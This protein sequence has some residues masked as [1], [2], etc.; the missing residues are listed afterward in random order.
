M[1]ESELEVLLLAGRFEVRGS[2]AY[3]LRLAAGLAEKGI[4][5]R[6]V[7]PDAGLVDRQM[8]SRLQIEE[9]RRLN[10]P[11]LGKLL[12][13]Y[14]LH[15]ARRPIPHLIHIQSRRALKIGNWLSRQ[16]QR[17]YLV[18]MHQHLPPDA[19]LRLNREWCRRIIAVS[20]S[21]RHD[22]LDRLRVP[23]ELVTVIPC[24]VETA[25]QT[26]A[27]IS[28]DFGHTPVI[29][30][31]GPLETIKGFPYFLG[32]A[33]QVLEVRNNVEFL[34]AGAGPEEANLRRVARELGIADK[35]TFVPFLR[36]FTDS[37][38]ATDIFCLPSLQEGLGT[39]MLEAM[40]LARPVIATAV[41]GVTGV[42]RDGWNGLIVP[43]RDSA[44]LARRI[45]ELLEQPARAQAIG[46]QAR[47][48]VIEE[49]NIDTMVE[50]TAGLYRELAGVRSSAIATASV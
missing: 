26:D 10:T 39:V 38:A 41:G 15:Q 9:F 45:L 25:P 21:V 47:Q 29:G 32:A 18:T 37:L 49:Y 6:V 43:P 7:T 40:A 16:L 22:V 50:K 42:I 1:S 33:R 48:L 30:T 14:V 46:S 35:V 27:A 2:S 23:P 4:R 5:A 34:V 12:L 44:A 28:L 24:G 19:K 8:R 13:R 36:C 17:P 3:T 11:I 20:D 31:A